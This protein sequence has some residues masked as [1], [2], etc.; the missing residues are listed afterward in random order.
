[1]YFLLVTLRL[2]HSTLYL[3]QGNLRK[4]K[5][6]EY[7]FLEQL[8]FSLDHFHVVPS[9]HDLHMFFVPYIWQC[10]M[11]KVNIDVMAVVYVKD[12]VVL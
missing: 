6:V 5:I 12:G 11:Y 7:I 1:M 10:V 4:S 3:F 8:L 2:N 9:R